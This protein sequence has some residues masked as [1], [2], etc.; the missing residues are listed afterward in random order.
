MRFPQ[1]FS[2]DQK[3]TFFKQRRSAM[4]SRLR[5]SK[6]VEHSLKIQGEIEKCNEALN[7]LK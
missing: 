3:V 5:K 2:I 4:K 1:T 6:N 7:L